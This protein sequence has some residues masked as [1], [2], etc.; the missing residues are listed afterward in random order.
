V[1]ELEKELP[2]LLIIREGRKEGRKKT[3]N[4]EFEARRYDR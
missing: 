3:I 1:L 4:P 2:F